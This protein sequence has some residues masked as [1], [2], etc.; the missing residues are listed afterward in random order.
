MDTLQLTLLAALLLSLFGLVRALMI[1]Q[2]L[3]AERDLAQARLLAGDGAGALHDLQ[4]VAK[5]P[6]ARRGAARELVV[7][8]SKQLGLD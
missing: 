6:G 4:R 2:R 5:L 8:L 3:R 1:A 7:E